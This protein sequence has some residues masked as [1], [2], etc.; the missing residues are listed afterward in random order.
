MAFSMAP[1]LL[2][3]ITIAGIFF[4]EDAARG[5]L[6]DR[7]SSLIGPNGAD[8]VQILLKASRSP[9]GS[10]FSIAIGT[11]TVLIGATS[12]F[13]ELQSDLDIIWKVDRA[14][15][16]GV[17]AFVRA[18]LLSFGIVLGLTLLL[19][20]SL[21]LSALTGAI[22]NWVGDRL[23]SIQPFVQILNSAIAFTVT[24]LLFAVIYKVLPRTDIAWREVW[25]GALST[26]I[27]FSFGKY[28]IGLYI[29]RAAVSSSFGAAGAFV[30]LLAWIYYSAQI[31][32]L[33]AE[34]TY[35]HAKLLQAGEVSS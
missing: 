17:G 20:A 14:H 7:L 6:T 34:F 4:G 29:S 13:G 24:T 30:A 26:A 28:L 9:A 3:V 2:I 35:H 8:A 21:L 32:L 23:G 15:T 22:E 10:L 11:A 19:M 25:V 31:C 33:G 1:L 12:V 18:R 27:L 5:A 16:E